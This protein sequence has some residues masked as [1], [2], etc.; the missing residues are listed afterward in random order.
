SRPRVPDGVRRR[1]LPRLAPRLPDHAESLV[2]RRHAHTRP[3]RT[4]AAGRAPGHDLP[5]ARARGRTR[6]AA[7][8]AVRS[9]RTVPGFRAAAAPSARTDARLRRR[10]PFEPLC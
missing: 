1:A 2:S 6:V 7:A 4:L 3:A 10:H 5:T 9:A 8:F